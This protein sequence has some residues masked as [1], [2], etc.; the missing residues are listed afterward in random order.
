MVGRGTL[1]IIYAYCANGH[2]ERTDR[3]ATLIH[4]F[5]LA[6]SYVTG[7]SAVLIA[8]AIMSDTFERVQQ[9]M[10]AAGRLERAIIIL[11]IEQ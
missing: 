9:N 4:C 3:Q 2:D 7:V 6:K 1:H 11:E 8:A 5:A 10:S